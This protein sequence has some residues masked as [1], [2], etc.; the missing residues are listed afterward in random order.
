HRIKPSLDNLGIKSM[1]QI[2]RDIEKYEENGNDIPGLKE[3]IQ[4]LEATVN[5]V[6]EDIKKNILI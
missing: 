2:I 3:Q 6:V 1:Y 5:A 4:Q